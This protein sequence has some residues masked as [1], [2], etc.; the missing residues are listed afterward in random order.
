[1]G[2]SYLFFDVDNTVVSKKRGRIPEDTYVAIRKAMDNGHKCIWCTGRA[3]RMCDEVADLGIVDAVVCNGAGVVIDGKMANAW[4]IDPEVVKKTITKIEELDGGFQIQD[5]WYGVQNDYTHDHFRDVFREAFPD[6]DPDVKLKQKA[7]LH[8]D[9][10]T[11]GKIQ[12]ID[13]SFNTIKEAREFLS[14]LDSS[15]NY[16][17]AASYYVGEGSQYGEITLKGVSKG[18]GIKKMV[19]L[20][21]GDMKDT[22]GFGDSTND[23]EMLKAVNTSVVMGNGTDDVKEVADFITKDVD[24]GGIAYALRHFGLI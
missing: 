4:T 6:I 5:G 20:L 22:Y 17:T 23:L 16:I 10:Y 1:M 13:F 8:I 14:S 19:S 9:E 11:P 21:G 3:Y 7:M 12:K 15:L 24:D 18:E 2:M